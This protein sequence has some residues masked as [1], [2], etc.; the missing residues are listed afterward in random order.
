VREGG[1]AAGLPFLLVYDRDLLLCFVVLFQDA[2]LLF[3]SGG[4]E[5]GRTAGLPFLLVYDRD[6]LLCFVVLSQDA[7][8][9]FLSGGRG[10]R[11]GGREGGRAQRPSF[12]G[13]HGRCSC[14]C[15]YAGIIFRILSGGRE[16]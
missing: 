9:L 8:V 13:L 10:G 1:R 15:A 4:R 7:P 12:V 2:S 14:L 11:E 16:G 6:P 5:G 3:V